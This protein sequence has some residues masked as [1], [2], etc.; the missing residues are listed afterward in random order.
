MPKSE[1]NEYVG[2]TKEK[3]NFNTKLCLK[4]EN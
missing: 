2:G 1:Q 3:K 4:K